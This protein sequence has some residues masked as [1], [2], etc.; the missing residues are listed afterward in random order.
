MGRTRGTHRLVS[1]KSVRDVLCLKTSVT[2]PGA[3]V[4]AKG[5]LHSEPLRRDQALVSISMTEYISVY[6]TQFGALFSVYRFFFQI[7]W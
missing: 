3:G 2:S 1:G 4:E 6:A 5:T 7:F